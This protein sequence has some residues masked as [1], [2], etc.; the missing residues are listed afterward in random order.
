MK[1]IIL[2]K[3]GD[4]QL[5]TIDFNSEITENEVL[6]KIHRIG[7]CGTD[8]HAFKGDQ[9]FFTY[10]RTLGHELGAE[11]I[12]VG[13]NVKNV[14]NGDKVSVEPYLTCGHCQPCILGKTNCCETLQCLGVHT[15]GGMVEYLK[16]PAHK[17]H[18]SDVLEYSQLALVETLGIGCHAI[19]RANVTENDIVLVIGAGPIGLSVLQFLQN[20]VGQIILID[21]NQNRIDFANSLFDI[22]HNILKNNDLTD[23]NLRQFLNGNLPTVVFDATGNPHSMMN[24]F[25]YVSFGGKL[26]FVGLFQGN[27]T[28]SDPHFH[29]RELT[30]MSSRNAIATDFKYIISQMEAGKIN[31]KKWITHEAE[32]EKMPSIFNEWL[33]PEAKVIKALVKL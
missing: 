10:P 15:D 14:S 4:F 12:Q 1:T 19:N 26:V 2:Q 6:L 13:V 25:N 30:V 33:K 11:V 17:L 27:V 7:I 3:P 22:N 29:R 16:M 21:T 9:P 24:A 32:F 31:T 5:H 20:K 23:E 18:K 8:I 28:F